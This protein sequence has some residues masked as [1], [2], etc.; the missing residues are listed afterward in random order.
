[1][2]INIQNISEASV[3]MPV[4]ADQVVHLLIKSAEVKPQKKDPSA[5][6]LSF[7]F[8]IHEEQV[9][10]QETGMPIPNRN[11]T[12]FQDISLKPSVDES[13]GQLKYDPR[14]RIKELLLACGYSEEDIREVEA[15]GGVQ[16]DHFLN[17]WLKA[18]IV[19]RKPENGYEEK[20]EIR[21]F[22]PCEATFSHSSI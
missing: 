12:L 19:Y 14:V 8:K 7:Q 18:K 3:G 22:K 5:L 17:K 16:T 11:F 20:N 6:N 4:L 1:M 13:T 10:V 15:N 9:V 21:N 2:L